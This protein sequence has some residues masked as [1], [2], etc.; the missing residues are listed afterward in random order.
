MTALAANNY[1]VNQRDVAL[2][3]RSF[4]VADNVHIYKGAIVVLDSSGYAR[5]ARNTAGE[6]VIGIAEEEFDNT[7][8]GH[9]AGG[10]DALGR[11]GVK[12]M[13]GA[14]FLLLCSATV[15]QASVGQIFYALDD[16]TARATVSTSGNVIG[17]VSEF[18]DSTHAW[19]FIPTIIPSVMSQGAAVSG[20]A[21]GY[22]IAR[23]RHTQV[24]AQDTV[25]SGLATVVAVIVTPESYTVNQQWFSGAVGDQAGAPAAGS[26]YINSWKATATGNTTPIAA[27]SFVD[28]IAVDW[29]AI[30]T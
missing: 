23:G 7:I 28:N 22:K 24:A 16:G 30:G 3:I 21:N 2:D 8:S 27:T 12:V 19:I 18:V 14:H 10:R 15:T 20:V 26:F 13:S 17:V 25:V 29:V 4:K 5:P 11:A 9:A 6:Y 1:N